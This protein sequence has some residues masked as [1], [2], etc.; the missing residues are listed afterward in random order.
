M[1]YFSRAKLGNR[2]SRAVDEQF[3]RSWGG[4]NAL[5]IASARKLPRG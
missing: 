5:L 3:S 2:A 1:R 4:V